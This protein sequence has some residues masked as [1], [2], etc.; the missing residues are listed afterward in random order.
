M[1]RSPTNQRI[2]VEFQ[3]YYTTNSRHALDMQ[4]YKC[5]SMERNSSAMD[6]SWGLC[7]SRNSK[8]KFV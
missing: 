1:K 4:A 6:T 3:V 5:L 8:K 7:R 2:K